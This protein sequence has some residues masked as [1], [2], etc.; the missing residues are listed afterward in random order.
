MHSNKNNR[1]F[2]DY[3]KRYKKYRQE[4]QDQMNIIIEN[5]EIEEGYLTILDLLALNY[6]MLYTS[7]DDIKANGFEKK[8][9]KERTVKN[10]AVQTF[11]NAQQTII[12]L[13]NSFPTNPMSKAK[14]KKLSDGDLN[15]PSP[16][17]EY[18]TE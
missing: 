15:E 14:I 10:H 1:K 12:K 6:D 3:K 5:T 17:D 13:L 8:D 11:N 2:M 16:L 9:F 18:L 4:V 7:I